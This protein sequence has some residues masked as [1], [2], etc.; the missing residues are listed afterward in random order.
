MLSSNPTTGIA[1]CCARAAI[2]HA[3][4]PPRAA[5][6]CRRCIRPIAI[7]HPQRAVRR[8]VMLA[9]LAR[10]H[11]RSAVDISSFANGA[12][13]A[14]R[15]RLLNGQ[16]FPHHQIAMTRCG[17]A[18]DAAGTIAW[19]RGWPPVREPQ[20]GS[21]DPHNSAC[22]RGNVDRRCHRSRR[23][24]RMT[25]SRAPHPTWLSSPPHRRPRSDRRLPSALFAGE[26][27]AGERTGQP[28]NRESRN[29][30]DSHTPGHHT[31]ET[32]PA[33]WA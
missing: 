33:G 29:I 4:A 25:L 2:G 23:A 22:G 21:N 18:A 10:V 14:P 20:G 28:L 24:G 3:A 11:S 7:G 13:V 19:A 16:P 15:W 5:M 8:Y 12:V 32:R 27:S 6:N 17:K 9:H 31:A 26:A 30:G 1:G